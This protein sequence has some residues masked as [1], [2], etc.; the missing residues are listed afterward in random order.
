MAQRRRTYLT[1]EHVSLQLQIQSLAEPEIT[2]Y[3]ASTKKKFRRYAMPVDEARKVIDKSMGK[4][5]LTE[6]L[7]ETR[8]QSG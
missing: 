4:R 3:I 1:A 6:L 7:R 5:T 8:R 2:S